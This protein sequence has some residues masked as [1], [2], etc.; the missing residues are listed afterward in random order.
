MNG[1]KAGPL[2]GRRGFL[3]VGAAGFGLTLGDFFR[4]KAQA[5]LKSYAPITAKADSIIHIFLPWRDRPS[6]DVRPQ[7][8]RPGRISRR[9]GAYPHQ[10]RWRVLQRDAAQDRPDG[11][12]DHRHPVDDPRRGRPR[13]RHAQ[14][15]H[16]LPAQPGPALPEHGERGLARVRPQER[17]P[18]VCLRA[19]D[20]EHLCG[21]GLPQLVVLPVQPGQR[22]GQRRL[23]GPGPEPA[24]R[25]RRLAVRHPPPRPRR[26]QRPL[27]QEG[28]RPTA[29]PRWTPS[30]SGPTA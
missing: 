1:T 10:D 26:R 28:E 18:A 15:V 11:R 4:M 23:Q 20:A 19:D 22:P 27:R 30:T 29:W 9:A 13:A 2:F 25:D 21:H 3:T 8:L 7:A 14:H 5:D 17:P 16:R 6:G 12:Q 24:R